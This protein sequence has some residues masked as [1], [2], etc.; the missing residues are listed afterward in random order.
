MANVPEIAGSLTTWH[1]HQDLCW[2]TTPTGGNRVTG[3]A[4]NGQCPNGGVNVATPPM[5]H[6]WLEPQPCGPFAGIEGTH[7]S[8]CGHTH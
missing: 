2:T 5:L 4:V 7:G 6:V 1:D 8:A 3:I